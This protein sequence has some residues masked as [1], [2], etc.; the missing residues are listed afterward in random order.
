MATAKVTV[1][2]SGV[3]KKINRLK[4]NRKL[5]LFIS[6]EAAKGMN[7]YVPMRDGALRDSADASVPLKIT[8][9]TPYAHYIWNGISKGGG[10]IKYTEPG[11]TSHWE[12]HY[13]AAHG[14]E[15]GRAATNYV[16]G[17]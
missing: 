4:S 9:N 16:K 5:G 13:A 10:G 1:D 11:V 8:Y 17:L 14:E 2:M 15:L 6:S 3:A 12:E 7:R